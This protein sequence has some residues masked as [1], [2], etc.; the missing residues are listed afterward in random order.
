MKRRSIL[1]RQ[2]YNEYA[3]R[4]IFGDH[5]DLLPAAVRRAYLDIARSLRGLSK[6][7]D[8]TQLVA[9]ADRYLVQRL[10]D[11]ASGYVIID[12]PERYDQWHR[13]TCQR[14]DEILTLGGYSGA[15]IGHLQRWINGAVQYIHLIGAQH[16]PGYDALYPWCHLPFDTALIDQLEPLGMPPIAS[17]ARVDDYDAYLERQIWIREHLVFAPLDVAFYL[18]MGREPA[19]PD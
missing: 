17:W 13:A 7:P 4:L 8:H 3:L 15:T 12:G 10:R 5:D 2:D 11:I 9:D 14:I 18:T 1:S 16:L 6:V 19:L